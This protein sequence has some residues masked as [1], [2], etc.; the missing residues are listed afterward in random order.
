M[1]KGKLYTVGLVQLQVLHTSYLL[2]TANKA[3]ID[4]FIGL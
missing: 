4:S 2:Q 3:E 1:R